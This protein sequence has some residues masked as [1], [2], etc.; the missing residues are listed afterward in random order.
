MKELALLCRMTEATASR[1]VRVLEASSA[2][3]A[4]PPAL[5]LVDLVQ[6]QRDARSR[7]VFLSGE[8]RRLRDVILGL[9]NSL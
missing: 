8:G 2:A 4:L 1:S 3:T 6:S 7:L 5:G 9:G